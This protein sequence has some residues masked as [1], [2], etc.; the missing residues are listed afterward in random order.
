MKNTNVAAQFLH[1]RRLSSLTVELCSHIS[2]LDSLR[3]V[4]E[5][6][7]GSYEI[8]LQNFLR[9]LWKLSLS[10]GWTQI[11]RLNVGVDV[12]S[13]VQRTLRYEEGAFELFWHHLET[14]CNSPDLEKFKS[15]RV[16]C[17]NS[18]LFRHL[19]ASVARGPE[20]EAS[21]DDVESVRTLPEVKEPDS[22]R[23][24]DIW[25]FLPFSF[26]QPKRMAE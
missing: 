20:E 6:P 21:L 12:A 4:T 9:N 25:E 16:V 23:L 3:R 15:W 22:R 26:I 1:N 5:L 10:E 24:F 11:R 17:P 2:S 14:F 13:V 18:V 8:I 7:E 19:I